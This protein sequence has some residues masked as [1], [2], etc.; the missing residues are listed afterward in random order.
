MTI[1]ILE[2]CANT[3]YTLT[4]AL[5]KT[6]S[7][8]PNN[9]IVV[10]TTPFIAKVL[11]EGSISDNTQIVVFEDKKN[12]QTFF[13]TIENR[14]FDRLH[15]CTIEDYYHSFAEFRPQAKK[16]FLH[17]HDI[18]T[19]YLNDFKHAFKNYQYTLRHRPNRLRETARFVRDML[20]RHPARQAILKN[21]R[22]YDLTFVVLSQRQKTFLSQFEDDKKILAFP[23]IINEGVEKLPNKISSDAKIRI[24]I[25]GIVT[26]SRRD[27]SG[28]FAILDNILP[29]IK[30]KLV[31]DLLGFI[32]KTEPHLLKKIQELE[33]K[34]LEILYSTKFIDAVRFDTALEE[35]DIL[36]NNQV[37]TV[38]H[39]GQYG[40][41]KDSGLLYNIVRGGKPAI[42]PTSYAVDHE[43]EDVL[44]YYSTADELK[45][46]LLHIANRSVCLK[47]YQENALQLSRNYTP[48]S[49]YKKLVQATDITNPPF[50]T[51][52]SHTN[53]HSKS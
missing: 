14:S 39:T 53:P 22:A 33:Q 41:T 23:S 4:N 12:E 46:I 44:M 25:P 20:I 40:M 48:K 9:S 34:G 8:D 43:F 13:K 5:I 26:D 2:V 36:L 17:I 3:H 19:W 32:E 29:I 6:Y 31:F 11:Q 16:I 49:L 21:F 7:T 52:D 18:D 28:L 50:I 10:Y 1:A 51:N 47:K 15:I 27:Y 24:C 45:D 30:D 38:S 37:V 42:F 35:A